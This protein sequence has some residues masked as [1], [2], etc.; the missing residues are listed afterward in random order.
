MPPGRGRRQGGAFPFGAHHLGGQ[1]HGRSPAGR[2]ARLLLAYTGNVSGVRVPLLPRWSCSSTAECWSDMP[3]TKVRFLPA[4]RSSFDGVYFN[5]RRRASGARGCRC[6]SCHSDDGT[7]VQPGECWLGKSA[8]RVRFPPVPPFIRH[9][10]FF[11]SWVRLVTLGDC[12]SPSGGFDSHQGRHG[13]VFQR[14]DAVLARRRQGFESPQVHFECA[15]GRALDKYATTPI[16]G[17]RPGGLVVFT[18]LLWRVRFSRP[19]RRA[20]LV[21]RIGHAPLVRERGG[22]ESLGG[23]QRSLAPAHGCGPGVRS[24]VRWFDSTRWHE[25]RSRRAIRPRARMRPGSAKPG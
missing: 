4:P 19:R 17:Q 9:S 22:F 14:Q 23:L 10:L 8:T 1:T 18:R 3:A 5:R 21:F 24:L 2:G 6:K 12:L 11:W 20:H 16:R 13:P 15:R 7:V 25:R